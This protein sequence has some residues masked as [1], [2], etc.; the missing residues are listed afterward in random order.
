MSCHTSQLSIVPRQTPPSSARFRFFSSVCSS[1]AILA[2]GKYADRGIPVF[3]LIILPN[4]LFAISL[5]IPAARPHCQTTACSNGLPGFPIPHSRGFPL[6]ADTHSRHLRRADGCFFHQKLNCPYGIVPYFPEVMGNPALFI[7]QLSVGNI[8][9]ISI[10][11]SRSNNS[12]L[13]PCVL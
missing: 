3:S 9:R 1:H 6:V 11:P 12:A 8:F 10:F 5:T 2:A 13:V 7:Y 4:P